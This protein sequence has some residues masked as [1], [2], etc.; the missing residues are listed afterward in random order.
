[1]MP[2]RSCRGVLLGLDAGAIDS[3]KR[4]VAFSNFDR[5]PYARR[6]APS[7]WGMSVEL[8]ATAPIAVAPAA[9]KDLRVTAF[10]VISLP[11]Q[12]SQN[13]IHRILTMLDELCV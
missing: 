3:R 4:R 11:F 7:S 6:G 13:T 5:S 9:R 1:M 12:F 10:G 8:A 2:C